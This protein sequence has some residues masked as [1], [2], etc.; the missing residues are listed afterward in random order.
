MA[1]ALGMRELYN[2]AF[3]DE[4]F[5]SHLKWEPG[6]TLTVQSPV[7]ENWRDWSLH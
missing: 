6:K 7:S 1:F 4:E 3:F 2:Y 5:L